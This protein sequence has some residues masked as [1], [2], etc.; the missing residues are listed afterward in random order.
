[1][2]LWE[3]ERREATRTEVASDVAGGP[4]E[5][6]EKGTVRV[7]VVIPAVNEEPVI[8]DVVRG[9]RQA[10]YE[11]IVV[12]DGSSDDT[13]QRASVGGAR[14]FRHPLNRGKGAAVRTGMEAAKRLGADIVI[15]MDGDGQHDPADL[16]RLL[17]PLLQGECDVVLGVRPRG[18]QAM[19][20]T[21]AIANVVGNLLTSLV[22]GLW[23]SDSQSGFR[24]F[25]RRAADAIETTA[26]TYEYDSE[27]I[28][29][30]RTH[31]LRFREVPI[32]TRYTPYSMRKAHR[33]TLASG[34]QT[35]ARMLWRIVV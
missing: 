4:G 20:W 7:L 18:H 2:S 35:I 28:R 15:T 14:V 31:H 5:A 25:A 3:R 32:T 21:R 27:V 33:Q 19:P 1:M 13:A 26:D 6:A 8:E 22:Y 9:V 30:I 29:E 10:G 34:L 23:V 12:D 16:P 11:A 24:A 17:A